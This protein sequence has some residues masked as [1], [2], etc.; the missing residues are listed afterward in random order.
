MTDYIGS[1]F[2]LFI[3][4]QL[5]FRQG[6]SFGYVLIHSVDMAVESRKKY[7]NPSKCHHVQE[8]KN[9]AKTRGHRVTKMLLQIS[10]LPISGPK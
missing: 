7:Y 10:N 5:P 2:N 8:Q 1:N 6:K 4:N 3:S 9:T